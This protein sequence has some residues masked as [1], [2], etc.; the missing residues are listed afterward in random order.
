MCLGC[1]WAL[2]PCPLSS[3]QLS[4]PLGRTAEGETR[5]ARAG[6]R[7]QATGRLSAC[8]YQRPVVPGD[9]L[10][11]SYQFRAVGWNP[12]VACKQAACPSSSGKLMHAASQSCP[13]PMLPNPSTHI[14]RT[15]AGGRRHRLSRWWASPYSM[16]EAME[17]EEGYRI[18]GAMP[19]PARWWLAP[20]VSH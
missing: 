3:I 17:V 4:D 9:W 13:C 1:P 20:L 7:G 14:R 15:S 11:P 18:L 12:S 2:W 10:L 6:Q 19:S 16:T 5:L 8:F